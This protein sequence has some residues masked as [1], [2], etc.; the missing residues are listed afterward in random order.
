MLGIL[1]LGGLGLSM[2]KRK[3]EKK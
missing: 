2:I 3:Q 1:A